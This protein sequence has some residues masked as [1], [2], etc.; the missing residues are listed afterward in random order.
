MTATI[1]QAR[2]VTVRVPAKVNLELR[3]GPL[4]EDGFHA[5]AT[6]FHAVG[7]FDDVTVTTADEFSITVGGRSVEKVPADETNLAYRAAQLIAENFEEA[8][9]VAIHI[10]KS[11]PV[12]G[13][14]AG[15]SA[16]AAATLV[17]C[18]ALFGL[19][20]HRADLEQLAAEL[21]SD[22]PFAL[23]GGTALGAGRGEQ[24]APVLSTGQFHW[25]F[26]LTD[27]GLPTPDVYRECDRLRD[28]QD[29]PEP[30]PNAQLLTALRSGDAKSVAQHMSNDLEP[31]A[32][33][34]M[35]R[36]SSVI[37][38]GMQ[39]GAL[40]AMVSGSGPTV[41]FLMEDADTA[42][43]LKRVLDSGD[44]VN[45]CVVTTSTPQGAHVIRG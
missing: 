43:A 20:L 1:P 18:D 14:M 26:A 29:I 27:E 15:G 25:L 22:V 28:G 39:V 32:L 45:D 4:R 2:T 33:S 10:E 6:V 16:D 9:P 19:G 31:A 12:A 23:T 11:I 17:A 35:P 36:L 30:A 41:A 37:D 40:R 13:G 24:V 5:L 21:G 8:G 34:L 38:T 42:M 44:I 7:L 3:V